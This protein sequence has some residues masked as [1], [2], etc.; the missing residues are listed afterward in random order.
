MTPQIRFLLESCHSLFFRDTSPRGVPSTWPSRVCRLPFIFLT[1]SVRGCRPPAQ[2][3]GDSQPQAPPAARGLPP[4][5]VFQQTCPLSALCQLTARHPELGTTLD[6][7]SHPT[8]SSSARPC[9]HYHQSQSGAEH[10]SAPLSLPAWR[11]P[12]L[13]QQLLASLPASL[14]PRCGLCSTRQLKWVFR[15]RERLG[16]GRA[17]PHSGG[18]RL[19]EG[20][21]LS[22]GRG[23]EGLG[24]HHA[25]GPLYKSR[26]LRAHA[27]QLA[28]LSF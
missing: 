23:A 27:P 22:P 1:W 6:F 9:Q 16:D 3:A 26:E 15:L 8:A 20:C 13:E 28:A 10:F 11:T 24:P 25:Q 4:S 17:G 5:P 19:A 2:A 7:F 21:R 18:V 14:C 12:G